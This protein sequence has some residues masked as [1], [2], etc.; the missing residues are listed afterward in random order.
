MCR[1]AL[2]SSSTCT[3]LPPRNA[4]ATAAI[5][6]ITTAKP[7]MMERLPTKAGPISWGKKARLVR[8][9]AWAAERWESTAG[10]RRVFKGL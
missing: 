2:D 1:W 3:N 4:E 10:P 6:L 5:R 9:A 8:F 7:R